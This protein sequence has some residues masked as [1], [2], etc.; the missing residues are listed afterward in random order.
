MGTALI[1][2]PLLTRPG[3]PPVAQGGARPAVTSSGPGFCAARPLSHPDGEVNAS[4]SKGFRIRYAAGPTG[5]TYSWSGHLRHRLSASKWR[6]ITSRPG[7][8]LVPSAPGLPRTIR[9][10]R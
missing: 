7:V 9:L 6:E 10:T 5:A 8:S 1:Q 4:I 2:Q 3:A